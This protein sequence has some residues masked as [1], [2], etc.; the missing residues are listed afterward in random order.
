MHPCESVKTL[1][2]FDMK[3]ESTEIADGLIKVT[4]EGRLDIDGSRAID[5]RFSFMTT[6]RKVNVI[7]DISGISFLASIG[8]RTLMTAAR[9]QHGRGGRLVLAAAQP[10]VQK[11]L[12]TAGI[13]QLIPTYESVDAAHASF[14]AA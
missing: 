3:I 7:V 2:N 10:V 4:L 9:G 13:D 5:D 12:L 8:I 1:G 6:T 11:V 14:A